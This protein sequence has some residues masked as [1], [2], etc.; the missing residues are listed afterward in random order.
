MKTKIHGI[1]GMVALLTI[2]T[3]WIST[4]FVEL[5][6]TKESIV[7]IKKLIIWGMLILIP[8]L[9]ATAISGNILGKN[10]ENKWIKSKKKRMPFI[11]LNGLL[12]LL[13]SAITLNFLAS[14]DEFYTTFYAVQIV[15]L[16]AGSV[17][18]FLLSLSAKE[19]MQL[20]KMHE[21]S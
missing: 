1:S 16:L 5:F 13:P 9:I 8:A 3:F 19:G 11:A 12:I 10:S 6:G 4:A 17:N 15:E 18:I 7:L 14:S 2:S 20:S 21:L